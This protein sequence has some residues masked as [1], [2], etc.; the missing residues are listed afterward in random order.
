MLTFDVLARVDRVPGPDEKIWGHS[1]VVTFGGP[2]ANAAATAAALGGPVRLL[3]PHGVSP[4]AGLL[5]QWLEVAGVRWVDP[6]PT[7]AHPSPIS[8][9]LV[10]EATG[11]RAV[12]AGAAPAP[13]D[14][15]PVVPE[16]LDRLLTGVGALLVDGHAPAWALAAA[17]IAQERGIPVVFDGGSYK[18]GTEQLL[19]WVDVAVLSAAFQAPD[20]SDPLTWVLARGPGYAAR[21]AGPG[22]IHARVA[23]D[24]LGR[25][26]AAYEVRVPRVAVRDTL[27][28][29]DVLHGALAWVL[30]RTG[31]GRKEFRAGLEFAS[32]VAAASCRFAGA[33]G[34]TAEPAGLA[35]VLRLS[36]PF[37]HRTVDK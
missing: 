2:A 25:G 15:A 10:T 5:G 29:G 4:V 37:A 12:V 3:A 11:E 20:G 14:P 27:G 16:V 35:A 31:L 36:T 23:V 13:P 1:Q 22:P 19:E 34:W 8:M 30:A 18:A 26:A 28:A 6:V 33:R 9:V 32:R 17:R 21:S 24:K 7:L